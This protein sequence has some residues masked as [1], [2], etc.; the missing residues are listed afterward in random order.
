[1]YIVD[2]YGLHYTARDNPTNI[3]EHNAK[4][5][6]SESQQVGCGME[7][8]LGVKEP[9]KVEL[10]MSKFVYFLIELVQTCLLKNLATKAELEFF[11]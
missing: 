2:W 5:I 9:S 3:E 4:P 11:Y 6:T 10:N 7:N 1:M 8:K